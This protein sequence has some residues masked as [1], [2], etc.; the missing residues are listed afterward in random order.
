MTIDRHRHLGQRTEFMP[1]SR[2]F[3]SYYGVPYSV[4]MGMSAWDNVTNISL[5]L[6][7]GTTVIEQPVNLEPL[8]MQYVD[9]ATAYLNSRAGQ[10]EP[11]FL[12]M[13]AF[14]VSISVSN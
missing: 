10:E 6:V 5:P 8:T 11:F 14:F 1:T 9:H 3:D 12:C 13:F 7:N 2:G 4:D